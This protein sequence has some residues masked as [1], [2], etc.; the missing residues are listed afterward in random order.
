[1][2]YSENHDL[3]TTIVI[4]PLIKNYQQIQKPMGDILMRNLDKMN[5]VSITVNE[6]N[7]YHVPPDGMH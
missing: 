2:I 3:T 6:T 7:R 1:M 4:I 5:K